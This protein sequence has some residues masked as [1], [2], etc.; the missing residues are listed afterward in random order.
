MTVNFL[1]LLYIQTV[2]VY[3]K[4]NYITFPYQLLWNPPSLYDMC[5]DQTR[6]SVGEKQ[7]KYQQSIVITTAVAI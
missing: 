6:V 5:I 2:V 3:D 7:P 1:W 4:I